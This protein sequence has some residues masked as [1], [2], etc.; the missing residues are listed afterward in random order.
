M[1]L[2]DHEGAPTSTGEGRL[3]YYNKYW[4][5]VC[6]LSFDYKAAKIACKMMGFQTGN[7]EG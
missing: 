3:E 5:S 7:I 2:V 4:G 1:R 6:N